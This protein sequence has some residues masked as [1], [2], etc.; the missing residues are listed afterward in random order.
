MVKRTRPNKVKKIP[1]DFILEILSAAEPYT[2]PMFGCTAVYVGERI[3][4]ILRKKED[5][6]SD[7]GVWLATTGEHHASLAKIFPKM[8]SLA[9]FGP[10][11]TGWQILPE[12]ADD[13]EESVV[14]ACELILKNDQRIG[15]VPK[16]KSPK[17]KIA[18]KSKHTR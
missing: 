11:P 4:L 3:V 2:K 5:F 6:T 1:F 16:R 7:N 13:F 12:D 10:G 18:K 15:K 14:L 8:R 17:K 9:L